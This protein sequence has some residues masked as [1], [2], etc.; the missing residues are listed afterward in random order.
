MESQRRLVRIQLLGSARGTSWRQWILPALDLVIHNDTKSLQNLYAG[1]SP[2]NLSSFGH[3]SLGGESIP[4]GPALGQS[5]GGLEII[6][7]N[8]PAGTLGFSATNYTTVDTGGFVTITV[9]RTNGS[10]GPVSVNYRTQNGFTNGAG[11]NVAVAGNTPQGGDYY[12][13]SGTLN[14]ADGQTSA[15]FQVEIFDHSVMQPTKFLNVVL[16]SPN[17][18]ATLDSSVPPLVPSTAVVEIIDGNF[19]PGHLEFSADL[20][21]FEGIGGDRHG[22]SCGRRQKGVLTVQCA[23]SDSARRL[24]TSITSARPPR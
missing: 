5:S 4:T 21:R 11:T 8:F 23:T 20:Q 10:T 9:L 18:A 17:G 24:P 13:N 16:S 1:L 12:T 7:D 6:N 2:L 19:L 22:E 15:S 3:F 14:F